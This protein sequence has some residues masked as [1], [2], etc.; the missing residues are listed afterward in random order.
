MTHSE[1][2]RLSQRGAAVTVALVVL[3]VALR[4]IVG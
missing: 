1:G 4:F 2:K 3:F